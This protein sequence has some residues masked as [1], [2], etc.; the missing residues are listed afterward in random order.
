MA[1]PSAIACR[2]SSVRTTSTSPRATATTSR[3][4]SPLTESSIMVA[5]L[6]RDGASRRWGL[7]RRDPEAPFVQPLDAR[8]E[9]LARVGQ[10]LRDPVGILALGEPRVAEVE[11]QA[12][13]VQLGLRVAGPPQGDHAEVV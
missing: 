13:E 2:A 9:R 3:S 6:R 4:S 7:E 8:A 5:R 10:P 11:G 1:A 12:D